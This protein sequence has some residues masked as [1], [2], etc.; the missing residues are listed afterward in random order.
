MKL[1]YTWTVAH[2]GPL[3]MGFS[4]QEYWSGSHSLFQGF[5]PTQGSD[6]SLLHCRQNHQGSPC[7]VMES[8][9]SLVS[10]S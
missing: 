10:S 5:F 3:S 4:R 7:T 2:Q 6:L 1:V 9:N 8:S